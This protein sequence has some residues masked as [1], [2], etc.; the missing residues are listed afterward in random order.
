MTLL[1]TLAKPQ[2]LSAS[3]SALSTSTKLIPPLSIQIRL[4]SSIW[5]TKAGNSFLHCSS[6]RVWSN[7]ATVESGGGKF[8]SPLKDEGELVELK[9][10][11]EE[12]V[13]LEE[14]GLKRLMR[15][16]MDKMVIEE[17]IRY[18]RGGRQIVSFFAVEV[19]REE[20]NWILLAWG[21]VSADELGRSS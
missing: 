3:L 10:W 19:G 11:P 20:G 5:S 2:P 13:G 1:L 16:K 18:L 8:E 21:E 7:W 4:F 6:E 9:L 15:A 14:K 12:I 17:N